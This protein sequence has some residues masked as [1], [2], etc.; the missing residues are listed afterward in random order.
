MV[1]SLHGKYMSK[2]WKQWCFIFLGLKITADSD[3][4][5]EIRRCLPL[6]RNAMTN[7]DSTLKSNDFSNKGPSNQSYGF[8]SFHVSMWELDHKEDWVLKRWCF[9][10]MVLEMTL[11]SSSDCKEIKPVNSKGNQPWIFI[12][13]SYTEAEGPML[14]LPDR[15][16]QLTGKKNL[17]AGNDWGQKKKVVA[18]SEMVR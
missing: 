14:W 11:V 5:H 10:T 1:P 12:G 6:R 2:M 17:D 18:G 7:L 13:S 4:S 3:C 16:S 9:W 8:S 15:K